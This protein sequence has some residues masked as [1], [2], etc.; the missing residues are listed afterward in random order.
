MKEHH[1][2]TLIYNCWLTTHCR[3]FLG[4]LHWGGGQNFHMDGPVNYCRGQP[5]LRFG[6]EGNGSVSV[7]GVQ[8]LGV[9]SG[10]QSRVGALR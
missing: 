2:L 10:T 6:E 7:E 4:T 8:G 9:G 1:F 3:Q 5:P